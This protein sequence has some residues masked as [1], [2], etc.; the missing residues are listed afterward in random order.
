MQVFQSQ[1]WSMLSCVLVISHTN[2]GLSGLIK[3]DYK[4]NRTDA[5]RS[6]ASNKLNKLERHNLRFFARHLEMSSSLSTSNFI[7]HVSNFLCM[8]VKLSE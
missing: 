5:Y 2:S 7:C 3:T 4:Y 6:N 8:Y 1:L